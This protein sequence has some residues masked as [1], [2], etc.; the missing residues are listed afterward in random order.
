MLFIYT[1]IYSFNRS[2]LFSTGEATPEFP[3]T[4]ETWTYCTVQ[5]RITS[6]VKE[7]EHLSYEERQTEL[8]L[9]SLGKRRLRG[10][11][12]IM[13]KYLKGGCREDRTRL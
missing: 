10:E 11:F 3:T 6:M 4:R 5:P 8:T 2:F 1:Y 7:L 9:F 12:F 13:H